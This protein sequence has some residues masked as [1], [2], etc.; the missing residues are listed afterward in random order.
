MMQRRRFLA[1]LGVGASVG[2]APIAAA[3]VALVPAKPLRPFFPS[4]PSFRKDGAKI[5]AED[6]EDLAMTVDALVERAT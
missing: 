1:L 4:H 3:V 2:L 6:F 5:T